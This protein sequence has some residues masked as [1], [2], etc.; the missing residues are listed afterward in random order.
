MGLFSKKDKGSKSIE[1]ES[2]YSTSLKEW[3]SFVLKCKS[4]KPYKE[5]ITFGQ[6]TYYKKDDLVV[7]WRQSTNLI[8]LTIKSRFSKKSTTVREESEITLSRN[9]LTGDILLFLKRLGLKKLFKIK[10]SCHIFW[11]NDKHGEICAVVYK[12]E[13]RGAE[14][15]YFIELEAEKSLPISISKNMIKRWERKLGLSPDKIVN[16]SLYEIYSGEMTKMVEV[17]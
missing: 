12:V 2:K 1:V 13:H 8:E 9:N 5:A 7:R 3:D 4:Q 15:K 11:F 10:K 14:D 16:N 6:D 17:D